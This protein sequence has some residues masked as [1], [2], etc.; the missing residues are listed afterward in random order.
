MPF[1]YRILPA[2]LVSMLLRFIW[3]VKSALQSDIVS[4][5]LGGTG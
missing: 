5:L 4:E 2:Q 3:V 1:T